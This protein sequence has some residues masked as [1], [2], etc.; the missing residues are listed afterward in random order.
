MLI[1]FY[2]EIYLKLHTTCNTHLNQIKGI[3]VSENVYNKI[4]LST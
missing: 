1:V 3:W 2:P 4:S